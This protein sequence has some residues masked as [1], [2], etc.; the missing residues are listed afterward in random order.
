MTPH[1]VSA[2]LALAFFTCAVALIGISHGVLTSAVAVC[3]SFG[4]GYFYCLAQSLRVKK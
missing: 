4:S 1:Q 3:L 2:I